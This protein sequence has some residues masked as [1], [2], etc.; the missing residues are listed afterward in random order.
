MCVRVGS[1]MRKFNI[2]AKNRNIMI[3]EEIR[4]TGKAIKNIK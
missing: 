2:D 3:F 4:E 1:Q